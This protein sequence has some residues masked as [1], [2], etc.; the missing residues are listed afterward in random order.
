MQTI[1]IHNCTVEL[2]IP[3]M[4]EMCGTV[5]PRKEPTV[6][7]RAN[8]YL[9]DMLV[10]MPDGKVATIKKLYLRELRGNMLPV[11]DE[12]GRVVLFTLA[13]AKVAPQLTADEPIEVGS[14]K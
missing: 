1:V 2:R 10:K 6:S 11:V 5:G 7:L 9:S 14:N 4:L 13:N 8:E 3:D 12:A